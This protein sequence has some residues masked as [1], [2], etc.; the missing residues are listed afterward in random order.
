MNKSLGQSSCV[1]LSLNATQS[2]IIIFKFAASF[3]I[4]S[5]TLLSFLDHSCSWQI[6][7]K[8][9][10]IFESAYCNFFILQHEMHFKSY[11]HLQSSWVCSCIGFRYIPT[12]QG[13]QAP[14]SLELEKL[15]QL[16]RLKHFPPKSRNQPKTLHG[17]K[18]QK[19][20]P[21]R[22]PAVKTL[23]LT[24]FLNLYKLSLITVTI[25]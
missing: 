1:H 3:K 17:L 7:L 11:L 8:S 22:I 16:W 15:L 21:R 13:S 18:A 2:C 19:T 10:V 4:Y 23:K 5:E 9:L 25:Q 6:S 20:T 14:P 12:F 24:L